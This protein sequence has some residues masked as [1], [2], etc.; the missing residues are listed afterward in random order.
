MSGHH[1]RG[2][3]RT[4]PSVSAYKKGCRCDDCRRINRERNAR[5][6][7]ALY[8]RP[9]DEVP[10][11]WGGY[12]NWGCRCGTCTQANTEKSRDRQRKAGS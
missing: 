7:A 5:I 11:G 3:I 10:H 12:T 4:H 6:R 8:A 1:L 9:R 2:V